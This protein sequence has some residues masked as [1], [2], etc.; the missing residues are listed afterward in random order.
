MVKEIVG[1]KGNCEKKPLRPG[2]RHELL[3]KLKF[4]F[5]YE[6]RPIAS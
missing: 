2:C 1:V 6:A 3:E 5:I 4:R